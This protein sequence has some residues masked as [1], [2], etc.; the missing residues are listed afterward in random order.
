MRK[1]IHILS[2]LL[3]ALPYSLFSQWA[4]PSY[5]EQQLQ[6]RLAKGLVFDILQDRQGFM[7]FGTEYGLI[8]YDG[9][10]LR[11]FQYE[12]DNPY[13]L[14]GNVVTCLLED[15]L[16]HL[17]VGTLSSGLHR[18]EPETERFTRFSGSPNTQM[19]PSHYR[20]NDLVEDQDGNIWIAT[21]GGGVNRWNHQRQQFDYYLPIELPLDSFTYK[22]IRAIHW[23]KHG[24]LWAGAQEGLAR[25]DPTTDRFIPWPDE[26][27]RLANI[28]TLTS[29]TDGRL[30]IGTR[31]G[32]VFHLKGNQLTEKML[33]ASFASKKDHSIHDLLRLP[34]GSLWIGTDDGFILF[35]TA[36]PDGLEYYFSDGGQVFTLSYSRTGLMWLGTNDGIGKLPLK[37]PKFRPFETAITREGETWA[38][39]VAAV[40]NLDDQR[41]LIGTTQGP[42]LLE[43]ESLH[44]HRD[45]TV[46]PGLQFFDQ[47]CPTAQ[48]KDRQGNLWLA[49]LAYFEGGFELFR[50]APDGTRTDFSARYQL[51][52]QDV[53]RSIGED[54]QGNIWFGTSNGLARYAPQS[55][56]L[57]IWKNNP[58]DSTSLP[59][60]HVRKIFFDRRGE[61]WLGTNGGGL[62]QYRPVTDDFLIIRPAHNQVL[63]IVADTSNILWL[64]TQGG[65]N[66]LDP[67]T[68]E[69][70]FYT[71]EQGLPDNTIK[72]LAIDEQH[73]LWIGTKN[74]FA[75]LDPLTGSFHTF[76]LQD[77]IQ[78]NEYWDQVTL[79]DENGRLFFGGAGGFNYFHPDSLS[80]NQTPP[81]VLLTGFKLFNQTIAPA[82][83]GGI[84]PRAIGFTN[85]LVLEHHQKV[86]TFQYTALNYHNAAKNRFAYQLIGFDPDWQEVGNQREVTYTNLDPGHYV[87]RVKASNDD[88]LW[89]E[90]GV[91]MELIIRP[92]WFASWWAYLTYLLLLSSGIYYVYRFQLNRQLAEA[93]AKRLRELDIIK[94]QLYTNITHEFR[95]P[96][97][98]IQGPVDK[99]L[100]SPSSTLARTDLE[101]IRQ[102]CRRL[103]HLIHQMLHLGKLEAGALS[104]S[105][106]YADVLP[107]IKY[108]IDSF[109]SFAESQDVALQLHTPAG[110]I[111]M[112]HDQEKLIDILSNLVSNGIKFTRSPGTVTIRVTKEQE[113]DI[114]SLIIAVE[115]T[116]RGIPQAALDKIFDRFYQ[117]KYPHDKS[118][119]ESVTSGS[120][121]GLALSKKLAELMEGSLSVESTVG[122]GSTFWLQLPISTT[123]KDKAATWH[124]PEIYV[125]KN[126]QLMEMPPSDKPASLQ[127]SPRLLIVEDNADVAHFVAQNLPKRF[128]YHIC[129][130]GRLGVD[131]A[132]ENIP[133]LIISDV[134][135]PRMNGYEL[136]K[137][138]KREQKTSH[139]PIILLTAKADLPSKLTGYERGA[140]AYMAKPFNSRELLIRIDNLLES[141]RRLQQHY[142]KASG[143]EAIET[144]PLTASP[145]E[146][147]FLQKVRKLIEEHLEDGD[148]S[149]ESLAGDLYMSSAQLYR[150]MMALTGL[151]PI[152]FYR[153]I[154]IGKAKQLLLETE[155]SISEIAYQCGFNDPAYFSR[156]FSAELKENP[157]SFRE[158]HV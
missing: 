151:S 147:L 129:S 64:A 57:R 74:G 40:T 66:R 39:G 5:V 91:A 92:P 137:Q 30:L 27:G 33:P 24:Q 15:Q 60:N 134:M 150:K 37:R 21:E 63:D 98:L 6:E 88:G 12:P 84:L 108:I 111:L 130:D 29:D 154:Q 42:F 140:D 46:V 76:N 20:I 83:K 120:G 75:R 59:D 50:L 156:V 85:R 43:K 35:N 26:S 148:Y 152:K 97:T 116:G 13:S 90:N 28:S 65:L 70:T 32:K 48:W 62:A 94:T 114:P 153:S 144:A 82:Q 34:N 68:R 58:G 110:P 96:L 99:A 128:Q 158:N 81:P 157:S 112:D 19:G 77:G 17:W 141:R 69:L 72:S 135:M 52:Q 102:N 1:I 126:T 67:I 54:P 155:H 31:T 73:K 131:W 145:Q 41:L 104:P 78:E 38:P 47:Y 49:T 101:K 71:T 87:F 133:D 79:R 53:I 22:K 117:V 109:S 93:E 55:D 14:R 9:Y 136:T 89:N 11:Y 113:K 80:W 23:D 61:L 105:Y 95:T 100:E 138:L 107:T 7:W 16:G 123:K 86:L 115:D 36:H 106:T 125:P 146:H 2:I 56:S 51:F 18:F 10:G 45:L 119:E 25:W 124:F 103:L 8:R 122:K 4:D 139:I 132:T 44:L 143:L 127:E 121:I 3:V 142:L 149:I 118:R